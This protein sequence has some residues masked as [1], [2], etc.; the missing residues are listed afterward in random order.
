[1]WHDDSKWHSYF[2][3]LEPPDKVW[4]Q[5]SLNWTTLE[6]SFRP[7]NNKTWFVVLFAKNDMF[8]WN[9]HEMWCFSLSF[10]ILMAMGWHSSSTRTTSK[11]PANI[12][13][14]LANTRTA[15]KSKV[16]CNFGCFVSACSDSN[17]KLRLSDGNAKLLIKTYER[18]VLW[19]NVWLYSSIANA[20]KIIGNG[21][22]GFRTEFRTLE[23][24]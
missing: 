23:W 5:S 12:P 13:Q 14:T 21:D 18:D 24:P 17:L 19:Q 1:M 10:G 15:R 11:T 7:S 8:S 9:V 4:G 3:A 16:S 20:E 2:Q 6:I 22:S